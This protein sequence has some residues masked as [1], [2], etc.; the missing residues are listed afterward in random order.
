MSETV[1]H[2][3]IKCQ[4]VNAMNNRHATYCGNL[5]SEKDRENGS[6]AAM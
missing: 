4:M 2:I 3:K 5:Q 6:G 1:T